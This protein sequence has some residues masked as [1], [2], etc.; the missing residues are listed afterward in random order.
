MVLA[1]LREHCVPVALV[2]RAHVSS[3]RTSRSPPEESAACPWEPRALC[4]D[5]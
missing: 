5:K 4:R 2:L 3:R 1:L